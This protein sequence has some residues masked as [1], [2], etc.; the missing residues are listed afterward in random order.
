MRENFNA[1]AISPAE[2]SIASGA[3]A[4]LRRLVAGLTIANGAPSTIAD[5]YDCSRWSAVLLQFISTVGTSFDAKVWFWD[6]ARAAWW[7]YGDFGTA[8]VKTVATAVNG[9]LYQANVPTFGMS[10]IY[11]EALNFQGV[12]EVATATGQASAV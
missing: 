5:G 10:R 8:G 3:T 4:A 7:F 9:G 2:Q 1:S 12:G 6:D 11:V